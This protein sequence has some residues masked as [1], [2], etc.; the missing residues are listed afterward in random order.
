MNDKEESNIFDK[1]DNDYINNIEYDKNYNNVNK[2]LIREI[3]SLSKREF[4]ADKD[5]TYSLYNK[6]G[7]LRGCS[8]ALSL[9]DI[10]TSSIHFYKLMHPLGCFFYYDILILFF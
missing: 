5:F 2:D 3:D 6:E 10:P 1:V 9:P 4:F 8:D 7:E